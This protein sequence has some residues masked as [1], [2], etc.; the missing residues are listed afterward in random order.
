MK[1]KK[2]R[3]IIGLNAIKKK[4]SYIRYLA[5]FSLF[6]PDCF[7]DCFKNIRKKEHSIL[8]HN[9]ILIIPR[10]KGFAQNTHSLFGFARNTSPCRDHICLNYDMVRLLHSRTHGIRVVSWL[11]IT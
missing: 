5:E 7:H 10:T 6:P 11:T 1:K 2:K 4:K 9:N 8:A 3:A